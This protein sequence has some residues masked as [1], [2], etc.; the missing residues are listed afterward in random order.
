MS[1]KQEGVVTLTEYCSSLLLT[2][3]LAL[4]TVYCSF[5][6]GSLC[7]FSQGTEDDFDW[8]L[9]RGPTS[10]GGTGPST[11]MSGNGT[12]DQQIISLNDIYA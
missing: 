11:D 8:T 7:E 10:S 4:L 6:T 9:N 12:F 2:F 5:D 1:Q 3:S